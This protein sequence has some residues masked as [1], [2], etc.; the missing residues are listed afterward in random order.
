[1]KVLA[2]GVPPHVL[3]D[4]AREIRDA[5]DSHGCIWFFDQDRLRPKTMRVSLDEASS[6]AVARV[7]IENG[8]VN[9]EGKR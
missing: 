2:T 8:V 7:L 3:D 5:I 9:V 4:V 1:M 6:I